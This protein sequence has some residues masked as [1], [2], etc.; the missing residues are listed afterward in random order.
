[1]SDRPGVS[2][3][4]IWSLLT[5]G[6]L[7]AWDLHEEQVV[8]GD[9]QGA[10]I[11]YSV[12]G[13]ETW[14]VSVP[15]P[16]RDVSV[17]DDGLVGVAGGEGE[18]FCL[19]KGEV[20]FRHRP[21]PA[22][23]HVRLGPHG[24]YLLA[25]S[26][27]G[28]GVFLNRF[29]R[30]MGKITVPGG[31]LGL[32]VVRETGRIVTVSPGG[33]VRGFT[34]WGKP[35][36]E[37]ESHPTAEAP[38]GDDRG[39]LVLVPIMA[40]GVDAYTAAGEHAGAYDVGEAV[41][42]AACSGNGERLLLATTDERL[43]LLKRDASVVTSEV[44]PA[45]IVGLTLSTDASLALVTTG[46]GYAHLLALAGEGESR[47]LEMR[48]APAAT[49]RPWLLRQAVFSPYS[50]VVRPR[51]AIA[52][53]GRYAAVAGDRQRV[54]V[55]TEDGDTVAVRRYAGSLLALRVLDDGDVRVYASR[56]I[57]R[58]HPGDDESTPE[59]VAETDL[60]QVAIESDGAAIGLTE[61]G[62]VVAV[63]PERGSARRLFSL[64]GPDIAGL[65]AAP[66]TIAVTRKAG[67]VEVWTREGEGLASCGPFPVTP[68]LLA[69]SEEGY[70]VGIAKLAILYS[71]RGEE[72]HCFEMP[73]PA[74]RAV[75]VPGG[76]LVVEETGEA[77]V[78]TV[79]GILRPVFHAGH[80]E[81]VPC[82]DIGEG[83]GF[84]LADGPLIQSVRPDGSPRW[85]FRAPAEFCC[86][87]RSADG[88]RVAAVAGT[89]LFV[90]PVAA[91]AGAEAEGG[92]PSEFLEFADG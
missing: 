15:A 9:D 55:V 75:D 36:W 42:I 68:R 21:G 65:A 64:P 92:A 23:D 79:T 43:V 45:P 57:F 58:F 37:A 19:L 17:G 24:D 34:S 31:V 38:S 67:R 46:S 11:G 59:W 72:R 66:G 90:F 3:S 48:A 63:P 8:L 53:D 12:T 82:P 5:P 2:I 40:Y 18:V 7:T 52:R 28:E 10:V 81:V 51:V 54:L 73:T 88:R 25:L 86:A 71:T 83:P 29:G 62:E 30:E 89:E 69:S 85:R 61:S 4:E 84:V 13:E 80:G 16:V 14:R 1:M 27:E 70:L 22:I 20:L 47:F 77:F 41:K 91:D 49:R 76:F 32:T 6:H 39:N 35:V 50:L 44:F 56:S 87:A 33:R 60:A 78:A 26:P 74:V